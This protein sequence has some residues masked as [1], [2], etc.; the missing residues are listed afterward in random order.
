MSLV[1]INALLNFLSANILVLGYLYLRHIRKNSEQWCIH[2][3]FL[4]FVLFWV[5]LVICIKEVQI[6]PSA[7]M[8][9]PYALFSA[10]LTIHVL[11]ALLLPILVVV[12][13]WAIVTGRLKRF[14][15]KMIVYWLFPV[16]MTA[17]LTGIFLY[18]LASAS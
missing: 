13:I 3:S 15:K 18:S 14:R 12:S 9:I 8:N 16:W 2:L 7:Y 6:L 11:F 4:A 17:T 5:S 10:I 1:G